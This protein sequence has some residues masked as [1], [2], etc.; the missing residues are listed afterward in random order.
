MSW[1]SKY[2]W[3][4]NNDYLLTDTFWH[5]WF[6]IIK[7]PYISL[8]SPLIIIWKRESNHP[9]QQYRI[10]A[11]AVTKH[12]NPSFHINMKFVPGSLTLCVTIIIFSPRSIPTTEGP[13]WCPCVKKWI[14][15]P[16]TSEHM[17]QKCTSA[18]DALLMKGMQTLMV[19]WKSHSNYDIKGLDLVSYMDVI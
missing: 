5:K 4:Y 1:K 19:N 6:D 10:L 18:T 11:L 8:R 7:N 3:V 2:L 16:W 12:E 13:H 9:K 14:F 17:E 15:A